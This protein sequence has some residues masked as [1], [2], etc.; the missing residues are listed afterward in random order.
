M[1]GIPNR[2]RSC[3]HWTWRRPHQTLEPRNWNLRTHHWRLRQQ[4][5]TQEHSFL[6]P[7]NQVQEQRVP[8]M[9]QLRRNSLHLG[10]QHEVRIK[11]INQSS[12]LPSTQKPDLQLRLWQVRFIRKRDTRGHLLLKRSRKR[13][14][15]H[16]WWKRDRHQHISAQNR[17]ERSIAHRDA[18]R[19]SDL[20]W[21]RWVLLV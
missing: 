3:R 12:G 18:Y 6:H 19:L 9:W 8:R 20:F 15:D 11:L 17:R 4:N 7:S 14:K 2:K 16:R 13:G 1:Y 5:E 10:N 21:N